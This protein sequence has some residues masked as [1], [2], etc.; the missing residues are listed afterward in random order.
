MA[1]SQKTDVRPEHQLY[2][3]YTTE[4]DQTRTN[5]HYEQP[6]E[7]FLLIT[8]GEWNV[9]SA[10]LWDQG[11][12]DD[13][14]S[15]QAKLDLIA[16][17]A[18][19]AQ[20]MRLIDV[21]CGWA[22]PLTYL[23]DTYGLTGTGLT[24]SP[25][26]KGYAEQRIARRGTD[27]TIVLSHWGDYTPP[28]QVDAIYTDEVIVHFFNL[29]GFFAKCHDWLKPG[30]V[31]INKELHL[32]HPRHAKLDRG[33]EFVSKIY[34]DTGNYRTLADETR[35]AND[36]GFDIERVHHIER[37]HYEK[38]IDHWLSNMHKH[39]D[40]LKEMVGDQHYRDFRVYLRLARHIQ[41]NV[42]LDVVV[43]RRFD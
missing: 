11:I 27:A 28:E 35:L 8:G 20:G 29:A 34:G 23:C 13:T 17:L 10:N 30:G 18:G 4:V 7:F 37:H 15:Q 5:V 40:Q 6:P 32:K 14:A 22:G 2:H 3:E 36:A 33:G 25:T 1:S 16:R 41:R 38:T 43:C 39:A 21:G 9:Y 26:Q 31:M 42:T 19:L 12:E 24:L